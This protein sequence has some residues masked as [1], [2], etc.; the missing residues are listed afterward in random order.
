[1]T[2]S[3]K[4]EDKLILALDG[5][6]GA[7]VFM[8]I[9]KLPN[10][11][12]VKVGLEL[13]TL[14]GPQIINQLRDRGKKV[15]LDLKFHD[16]PTTMGRACYQAAKTGAE[17]ITVHACAGKKGIEEA[18]KSAVK[19]AKEV[20]LPP[21]SLLAVTVLTS[22]GSKDFVQELGIQQSLDQR[23]SLLANLA[24]SAGIQG[25]ICSPLEVMKLRKDF[26]EPFQLITPG[27]RS[28]G[29]NINDQNR[30]MTPLEAIDAGSS[31]LV[32]GREVTSSENPSDA[33]NRICSQLI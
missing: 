31:K 33:F 4:P 14:L 20:G 10:L 2:L 28:C 6:S 21:P 8:L 18:N 17:L 23:V 15:F 19:G 16:I 7:E 9:E 26:P 11:I 25:C 3:F 22:W 13:F 24:S 1:M 32:I 27:I 12:W 5:M 30:I 29:E